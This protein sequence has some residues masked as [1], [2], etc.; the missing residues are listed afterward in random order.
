MDRKVGVVG[1]T[2]DPIHL[3]HVAL[4]EGARRCAGLDT[5]L[6][7]PAA[8]PP[9]RGRA[10]ASPEQRL[11]MCELAVKGH[12]GLEVSDVELRRDGPSYTVDTLRTLAAEM[13]G[14]EL[15]LVL[16]WDAARELG[17]WRRPREVLRL[18]RLLVVPR[19]GWEPP[20]LESLDVLDNVADRVRLCRVRTPEVDATRLRELAAEGA[21]LAG[22]VD[23]EVERYVRREGL[24]R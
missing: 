13:P 15:Y 2:F 3:G 24:Y 20:A 12:G 17:S 6:I 18:A 23:P 5:V 9:H 11:A 1:G 22:L 21:S 14:A 10:V 4:A 8:D 19:P 7:V 16:G